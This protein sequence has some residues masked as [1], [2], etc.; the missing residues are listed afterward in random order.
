[1]KITMTLDSHSVAQALAAVKRYEQDAKRKAEELRKLIAQNI[2]WS[3]SEGFTTALSDD[4]VGEEAGPPDVSVT[5]DERGD[6]SVVIASGQ[7]A[8]F[9]EFGAGVYH[10]GGVGTSPHPKGQE[11]GLTIGSYGK[12]QGARNVWGFYDGSGLHRS[13]GTPAA[14]P[15]YRGLEEAARTITELARE[16]FRT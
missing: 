2:A 6:V 14:M 13:R 11:L 1:M 7:D 9:V 12:G 8:V 4:L 16:V 15:M 5:V 10:N 3:A